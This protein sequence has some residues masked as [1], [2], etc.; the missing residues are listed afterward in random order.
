MEASVDLGPTG[1][2]AVP[3]AQAPLSDDQRREILFHGLFRPVLECLQSDLGD[4]K[5]AKQLASAVAQVTA[6]LERS[7][8]SESKSSLVELHLPDITRLAFKC[9][10]AGVREQMAQLVEKYSNRI[11]SDPGPTYFIPS[12][13]VPPVQ[14]DKIEQRHL[15]EDIFAST[16]RLRHLD[17]LLGWHPAF[18]RAFTITT[19]FLMHEQGALPYSTRNYLAILGASCHQC[20]YLISLQEADYVLNR[21]NPTWLQGVSFAPKKI[22]KLLPLNQLL[23]HRPWTIT[24]KH[25]AELVEG[26]DSWTIAELVQVLAI[27]C[28]FQSVSSLTYGLGLL[29]E[30]DMRAPARPQRASEHKLDSETR[31]QNQKNS[32]LLKRLLDE[33]EKEL[34]EDGDPQAGAAAGTAAGTAARLGG[35]AKRVG[36]SGGTGSGQGVSGGRGGAGTGSASKGRGAGPRPKGR[37]KIKTATE[38]ID[39]LL[40]VNQSMDRKI[41]YPHYTGKQLGR[42][43]DFKIKSEKLHRNADYSW[44]SHGYGLMTRF[45]PGLAPLLN[46]EFD[47]IQGLTY[48][49]LTATANVDTEPFRIAIWYYV[50]R[51]Y[52]IENDD[53]DYA[54]INKY[55]NRQLKQYIKKCACYPREVAC[56]DY[57]VFG[58]SFS[59]SEK[60]HVCIL[61]AEARRQAGLVYGL[62]AIGRYMKR[63]P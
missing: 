38:V 29:P 4:E 6:S 46:R 43:R 16:G 56:K 50:H 40:S 3:G 32:E 37:A 28:T 1:T 61:V 59:H 22:Q 63:K 15:F 53:Y 9:P 27:L 26:P 18:L 12:S 31:V 23:A 51:L 62:K 7:A 52:G 19:E 20:E 47:M 25:I 49:K 33:S 54:N 60:A 41:L 57:N 21:G 42:Y 10:F 5:R 39:I 24:D 48:R 58:Y 36:G 2:D 14:P 13:E 44:K 34:V 8:E 17:Q 45:Y 30:V 55:L 11:P 35:D